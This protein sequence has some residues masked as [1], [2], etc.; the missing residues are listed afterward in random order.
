MKKVALWFI[1]LLSILCKPMSA[2]DFTATHAS[3]LSK[4]AWRK[5]VPALLASVKVPQFPDRTYQLA[6]S[7]DDTAI[8]KKINQL[9][10]DCSA[11]GGGKVVIPKGSYL[12]KGSIFLRSN[13]HLHLEEGAVLRF[14]PDPKDYLPVVRVRW[15]GTI[16][17]NYSPLIYA[18]QEKNI[19][20]TGKGTI[21]GQAEKFFYQWKKLQKPDK[22][23]LRKMGNDRVPE[24]ER[25]FGEGHYLRP[26]GIQL[27]ECENI[28]LEDFTIKG[29][30]FWTIHPVLSKN[31]T[32]RNLK[33][34]A[35]TTN[36]DG[37]DPESCTNVLV[38]NC[39]FDTYDDCIAVKAGRDQDGW[40]KG[41][42]NGVVVR[43]CVFKSGVGSGFCIGSEMSGGVK[44]IFIENCTITSKKHGLNFKS[45]KDRGGFM[46]HVYIRNLQ[47]DSCKY[48]LTFTTDY[49]GWRGNNF[50][51]R[52]NDFYIEN[53]VVNHAEKLGIQIVGLEE[54][55]IKRLYFNKVQINNTPLPTKLKYFEQVVAKEV[56]IN[57]QKQ[58]FSL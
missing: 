15:E 46:E 43:N 8:L 40:E 28:L 56:L 33:V 41:S 13:V 45:N 27:H 22:Q 23:R 52:Y 53:V 55:P 11:K 17:Y 54:K 44:N 51:T 18:Y 4:E 20:I 12:L 38:E 58:S 26:D 32:A 19:A 47:I 1:C 24:K 42:T 29:S 34:A 10:Q 16:C 36:D 57:G 14:S 48:G 9:I 5:K 6:G 3:N 25:V 7:P 37:F 49:H 31:I 35:G 30:P 2:Q 50:P 21:D 39:V